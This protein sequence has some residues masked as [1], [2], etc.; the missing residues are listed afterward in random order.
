MR[1]SCLD[2]ARKH[3]AQAEILLQE[4]VLGYPEHFWLAIGHLAEAETE[5]THQWLHLAIMIREHRLALIAGTEYVFPAIEVIRELS[6]VQGDRETF[7][8]E[9]LGDGIERNP[10]T[11]G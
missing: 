5:L 11:V 1:K 2:C 10:P 6:T 9:T 8:S 4:S 3:V 7:L